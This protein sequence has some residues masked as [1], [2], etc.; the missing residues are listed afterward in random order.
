MTRKPKRPARRGKTS[1]GASAPTVP[2][3]TPALAEPRNHRRAAVP[4]EEIVNRLNELLE[5]ERAGVEA[6]ASLKRADTGGMSQV[7]VKKFAD[8]EA[9]ACAGLHRAIQAYGGVPSDR[10]GDFGRKVAALQGEGERLSLMGRG[11][12]WVV[13]RLDALL[14][15]PLDPETRAFL[16]EMREQHLENIEACN[17][18][19]EELEAPPSPPYRPLPLA[20]LREAHDQ[21][22]FGWWRAP[23]ATDRDLQRT[24]FQLGRYLA[25]L[26]DEV[27]RSRSLEARR[28]LTKARRAY[29]KADPQ[30]H[31]IEASRNLD[32]A[33]SFAH[34]AL[35]ALL[36][37]YRTPSHNPGDFESFYDVVG[38][39]FREVI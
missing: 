24:Y 5:A 38:V 23:G 4:D 28:Y 14:A 2:A 11:Q 10:T 7:D 33:L 3:G 34:S 19:A 13:K 8:D 27:Q 39:P 9:W 12:A 18:R 30:V 29:A 15:M 31:G 22:Y 25:G 1:G 37:Q 17:R 16:A 35:N 32:N 21:L 26:A 36:G 20:R 6:A